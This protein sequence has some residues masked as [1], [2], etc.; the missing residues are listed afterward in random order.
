MPNVGLHRFLGQEQLLADFP[1]HQA[2]GDELQN[3]DLARR[4]LLLQL[5]KRVL[6]R[7][8]VRTAGTAPPRRNFLETAR[9]RQVTAEDL[10]ALSSIHAPSI[11]AVAKPL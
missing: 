8:H 9:M 1:V 10:L 3:L 4:R 11:G 2:V 5:A 6:E 7:N